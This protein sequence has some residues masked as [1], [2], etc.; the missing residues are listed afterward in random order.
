MTPEDIS[1]KYRNRFLKNQALFNKKY[2]ALFD[3]VA[4]DI[5]DL[6]NNPNIRNYIRLF[7]RKT[8]SLPVFIHGNGHTDMTKIYN[9]LK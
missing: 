1:A 6:S 9:L 2:K 4:Q 3:R 7:N 8:D 5:A